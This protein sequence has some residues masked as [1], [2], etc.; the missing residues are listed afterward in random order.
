MKTLVTFCH[1]TGRRLR[2]YINR[3]VAKLTHKGRLKISV[4]VSLPLIAKIEV[5]YQRDF[6]AKA[7]NDNTP[8]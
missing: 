6:I 2:L 3:Q 7:G 8:K 4:A 1:K 5:S